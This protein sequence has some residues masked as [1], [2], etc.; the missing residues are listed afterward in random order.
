MSYG[1]QKQNR[2]IWFS[3]LIPFD[4]LDYEVRTQPTIGT[5]KYVWART[6]D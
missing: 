6:N 2:V 1:L 5:A 3:Q 4:S